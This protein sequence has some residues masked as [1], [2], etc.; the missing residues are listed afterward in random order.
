[1]CGPVVC[2]LCVSARGCSAV[3]SLAAGLPEKDMRKSRY[4]V[5]MVEH[6]DDPFVLNEALDPVLL[7]VCACVRCGAVA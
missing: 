1:M 4:A 2:M 6:A 3:C 7:E 5:D